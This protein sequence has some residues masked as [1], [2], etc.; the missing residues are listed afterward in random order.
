MVQ[1]NSFNQDLISEIFGQDPELSFLGRL[2]QS[3]LRPNQQKSLRG[4]LPE[5]L[6]RLRQSA[7]SSL[8]GGN[9]PTLL[10]DDFFKN[11]NFRDE[12]FK[13]SPQQRGQSQS[14]FSPRTRFGF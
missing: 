2:S 10:N 11:I 7:G 8:V 12:L 1:P 13:L 4:Q 6:S 5:F 9:I 14:R 3:G